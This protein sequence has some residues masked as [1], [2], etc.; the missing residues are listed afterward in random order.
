MR[1]ISLKTIGL[2]ELAKIAGVSISTVS[3]ALSDHP[4]V[5]KATKEAINALAVEHGFRLNQTAS[6]LRKKRTGAIG[7]VIP[8]GHEIDQSLSDPFF[9]SLLGPLADALAGN[10]YDLL[11]SRVI[12]RDDAWLDDV[13]ASGRVD[14]IVVIG[15]SDQT[16]AIERVAKAFAPIVVWGAFDPGLAQIT[17]GTDNVRGGE[18]AARHLI[19]VGRRRLAFLGDPRVPE[20]ADRHA[21][22]HRAIAEADQVEEIVLPLHL[23]DRD[24]YEEMGRFLA[25]HSAPDGIFAASDVIAMGAMRAITDKGLSVPQDVS[26]IGYDD[27]SIAAHTM[28]PLTTIR[29]DTRRG[30]ALLVELLMRR[31][32]GEAAASIAMEPELVLR[33]SA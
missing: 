19:G 11:L 29:Q 20:L 25:R 24:A 27:I 30:A 1:A 16:A 15:Q 9:M 8:L 14:G 18:L 33:G 13:I 6:A 21:G 28:P 10:G 3:R 7:V 5:S 31:L 4:R 26:V 32:A 12:P 23:T 17:V 22:F 2:A